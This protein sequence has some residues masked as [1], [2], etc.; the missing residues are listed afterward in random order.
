[1]HSPAFAAAQCEIDD[2]L[3]VASDDCRKQLIKFVL[4][5]P[6]L[7]D[8]NRA[9]RKTQAHWDATHS[10]RIRADHAND[11]LQLAVFP[12]RLSPK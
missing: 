9:S 4:S 11:V 5:A 2:P 10:E 8:V 3:D 1:M 7:K 6:K 12:H